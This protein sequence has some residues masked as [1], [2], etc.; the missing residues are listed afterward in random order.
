[1]EWKVSVFVEPAYEELEERIY[2]VGCDRRGVDRRG[3]VRITN[4]HRLVQEDDIGTGVPAV[5]VVHGGVSF[6]SNGAGA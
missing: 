3:P 6:I 2:V 5:W 4:T 1:M